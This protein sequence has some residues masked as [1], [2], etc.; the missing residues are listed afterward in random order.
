MIDLFKN[1]FWYILLRMLKYIPWTQEITKEVVHIEPRSLAFVPD[2]F[3]TQK[4]CIMAV[5]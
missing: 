4:M 1:I 5:E 3:K 2:R